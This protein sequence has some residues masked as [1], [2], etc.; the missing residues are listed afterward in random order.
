MTLA[1]IKPV[2]TISLMRSKLIRPSFSYFRYHWIEGRTFLER[3]TVFDSILQ[4]TT[5]T[6]RT[7]D[8]PTQFRHRYRYQLLIQSIKDSNRKMS[9]REQAS[10]QQQSHPSSPPVE[11]EEKQE[12]D[13]ASEFF[14]QGKR[15]WTMKSFVIRNDLR[16]GYSR[17]LLVVRSE[18][19][20]DGWIHD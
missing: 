14:N 17:E 6:H 19:I 10:Q 5:N 13:A 4:D 3:E 11:G 15:R 18:T 7:L 2:T 9:G 8:H 20:R 16:L 1:I 12:E